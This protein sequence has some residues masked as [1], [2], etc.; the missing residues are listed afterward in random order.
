MD[1]LNYSIPN[2][3]LLVAKFVGGAVRLYSVDNWMY[4]KDFDM[5]KYIMGDAAR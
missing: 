5:E 2:V 4:N 3:Y 1:P